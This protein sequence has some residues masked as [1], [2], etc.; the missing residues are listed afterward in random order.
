MV[1]ARA[2]AARV[3]ATVDDGLDWGMVARGGGLAAEEVVAVEE[4]RAEGEKMVAMGINLVECLD[5]WMCC[6]L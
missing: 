6:F 3:V 5:R 2:V 1:A 4:R